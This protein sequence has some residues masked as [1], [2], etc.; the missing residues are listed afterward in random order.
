MLA[1]MFDVGDLLEWGFDESEFQMLNIPDSNDAI[2][3]KDMENT[4]NECPKCGFKW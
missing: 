3:E 4:E 1:N 2:D